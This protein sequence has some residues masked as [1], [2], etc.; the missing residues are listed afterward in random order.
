[1]LLSSL[2]RSFNRNATAA[3]NLSSSSMEDTLLKSV[4]FITSIL[5]GVNVA[6]AE[7]TE[8]PTRIEIDTHI[9]LLYAADVTWHLNLRLC[10]Q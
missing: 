2:A 1:M 3:G 10:L 6:A 5:T 7:T 9:D 8:R 4:L